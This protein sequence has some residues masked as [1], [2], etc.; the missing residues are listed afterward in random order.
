MVIFLAS[1]FNPLGC[2]RSR[3]RCWAAIRLFRYPEPSGHALRG[4]GDGLN[5][6]RQHGQRAALLRHTF[7]P[8]WGPLPVCVRRR[9]GYVGH[10][11]SWQGHSRIIGPMSG[12]NIWSLELFSNHSAFHRWNTLSAALLSLSWDE[13]MCCCSA[14]TNGC[15]D[16]RRGAF[17]LDE[18]VGAGW[19][20]CPDSMARRSMNSVNSL[21][22]S[23]IS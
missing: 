7:K 5:N 15:L 9:A 16:L 13:L 1:S 22:Q 20:R 21:R 10:R 14:G 18:H 11:C 12:I 17:P 23:S 6:K 4:K 2:T 8:Q 3:G 19:S